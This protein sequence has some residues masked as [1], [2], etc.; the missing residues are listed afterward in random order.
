MS[1]DQ[2]GRASGRCPICGKPGE[3]RFQPFCS[4][5]CADVDL[6]RWMSGVYAIP[7]LSV[8][9]DEDGD[10]PA[11]LPGVQAGARQGTG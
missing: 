10:E 6:S 1:N 4:V 8:D 9:E 3:R 11:D 7:V 2:N 5:R